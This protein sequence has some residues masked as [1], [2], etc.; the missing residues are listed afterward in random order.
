MSRIAKLDIMNSKE[1]KALSAKVNEQWGAALPQG[2]AFLK[3]RKGRVYMVR[4]EAFRLEH[5]RLRIDSLGMYLGT[6]KDD[7]LRLSI[8]GSQLV[9]ASARKNMVDIEEAELAAWLIGQDIELEGGAGEYVLVRHKGDMLG[10][11][12]HKAGILHNH[13]P[14]SRRAETILSP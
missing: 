14:K 8:E 12:K 1:T 9:G 6:L 3:N 5:R 7:G 11:A 4:E 10:C 2:Y 13:M